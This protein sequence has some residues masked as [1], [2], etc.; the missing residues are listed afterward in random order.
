MFTDVMQ[1]DLRNAP[2]IIF[3]SAI[4]CLSKSVSQNHILQIHQTH[5][6]SDILRMRLSVLATIAA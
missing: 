4:E 5:E 2:I 3:I 1:N 6:F